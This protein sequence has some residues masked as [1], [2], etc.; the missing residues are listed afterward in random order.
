MKFIYTLLGILILNSHLIAQEGGFNNTEDDPPILS[1]VIGPVITSPPLNSVRSMAEWEEIES[2]VIVWVA[3]KPI[4]REIIKHA[5]EECEVIVICADS[6]EVINNLNFFNISI[7]N[8]A[9]LEKPFNSIW[10]RDYGQNTIYKNDIDSLKL[11]DWIYNRSTRIWDNIMPQSISEY[12]NVPLHATTV[13]PNDLVHTGGNHMSDGLGTAFSSKL[14]LTEN[15]GKYPNISFKTEANIDSIMK[16]FMGIERY[17]KFDTLPHD[18]IHHIDMHMKLLDEETIL[19]GEYPTGVADGPHIEANIQY[20]QNNFPSAF[21]TPYRIIRVPMP[22]DQ[23]DRFPDNYGYYRTY[24]NSVFV[25]KT[26]LVPIYE[27]QYDTIA[28]R[29]WKENMPG[30]NVV[31]IDCNSIIQARG[32]LHCITK[33]IGVKNPL[34]IVHQPLR[35]TVTTYAGFYTI[36][37]TIQHQSGITGATLYYTTDTSAGY[38]ASPMYLTDPN[39]NEWS[40]PIPVNTDGVEVF[41]YIESVANSGKIQ[42]RP[43]P[44]PA[45]YWNFTVKNAV[46][47]TPILQQLTVNKIFPNPADDK[48]TIQLE[49]QQHSPITI[50]LFNTLGQQLKTIFSGSIQQGITQYDLNTQHLSSGT[51]LIRIESNQ[52]I[53]TQPLVVK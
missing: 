26:I 33:A 43:M 14:V 31:G 9:F 29:V 35:D 3:Y 44:A 49:S 20:L 5:Q 40:A 38:I 32:A 23:F 15:A 11:V 10:I 51:Y 17:I 25:N 36:N 7:N 16:K 4:L 46:H 6:T 12:V 18:K 22:P 50:T 1:N 30:Y 19:I 48:V 45:G 47:T 21:G 24:T 53:M 37:A 2:L 8:V 13:A 28:L 27:E 52:K 39:T 41:Y 34:R 42:V